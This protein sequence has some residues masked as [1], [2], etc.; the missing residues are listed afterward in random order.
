MDTMEE[1]RTTAR[2][3]ARAANN[4]LPSERSASRGP[5]SRPFC[6]R[7][8]G[9][10]GPPLHRRRDKCLE[11]CLGSGVS[12][13][14]FF[15]NPLSCLLVRTSVEIRLVRHEPTFPFLPCAR[16]IIPPGSRT[17]RKS[18]RL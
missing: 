16:T 7:L 12:R 11:L 15:R 14:L 13:A 4:K 18:T 3:S 1:R 2:D 5:S 10:Q 6:F 17:D 8:F 9:F